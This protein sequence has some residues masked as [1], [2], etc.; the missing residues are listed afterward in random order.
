MTHHDDST[1]WGLDASEL[2]A[3]ERGVTKMHLED[4]PEC[5]EA[6]ATVQV[7]RETL[8]LARDAAPD[9]DWRATDAA[10]AAMVEARAPR[11]WLLPGLALAGA[12]AVLLALGVGFIGGGDGVEAAPALA[13]TLPAEPPS[14]PPAETRVASAEGLTRLGGAPVAVVG[15]ANLESGDVVR[16][17]AKGRALVQLPDD[18]VM[19]LAGGTQLALTR[20]EA[21]EVALTL[22]RGQVSVRASHAR[23]AGFAVYSG[24]ATVRVVGTVFAVRNRGDGVEV[25]VSEGQV[26]VELPDGATL[27]VSAGER[28]RLDA[29][30]ERA[31]RLGLTRAQ[32]AELSALAGVADA[33]VGAST[34]SSAAPAVGGQASAPPLVAAQ[35]TPR[36]L[37]RLSSAEARRRQVTAPEASQ[38]PA[39]VASVSAQ[40]DESTFRVEQPPTEVEVEA[41]AAAAPSA[42]TGGAVAA[43]QAQPEP[44]P[45]TKPTEWATLPQGNASDWAALPAAPSDDWAQLP[46]QALQ[47]AGPAA[48]IGVTQ[49][50]P[51]TPR[52]KMGSDLE[53]LFLQRAQGAVEKGDDCERYLLG[54]EEIAQDTG[55]TPRA[56]LSRVLRARCFSQQLRPRQAM[57]EYRKYLQDYPAGRFTGEAHQALGE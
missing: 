36:S 46:A 14:S 28:L 35:G 22:E 32:Q 45:V 15:G 12:V 9:I 49:S 29:K 34:S 33:V 54:L 37:P 57:N 20:V 23:R 8:E 3:G 13:Q 19:Q 26:Q 56:E 27:P 4:C 25:A 52:T 30:A 41:P 31:R 21:D 39:L 48:T 11:R 2:D 53:T 40:S 38:P 18:S 1:L 43:R 51:A 17:S 55:M 44:A 42:A 24:G 6:L 10:I 5:R 47:P 7:A 50:A 16:T